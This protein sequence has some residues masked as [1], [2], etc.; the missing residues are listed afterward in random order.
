MLLLFALCRV[1]AFEQFVVAENGIKK[2]S[3]GGDREALAN[4]D[5]AVVLEA[6][7]TYVRDSTAAPPR[8]HLVSATFFVFAVQ[9]YVAS[10]RCSLWA[11]GAHRPAG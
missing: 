9:L 5:E 11:I 3:E 1:C 7:A 6:D 4:V 8:S 10:L 2:E